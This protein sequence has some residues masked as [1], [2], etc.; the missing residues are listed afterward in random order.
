MENK[1]F[2]EDFE[3]FVNLSNANL[4]DIIV[5]NNLKLELRR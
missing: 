5:I 1:D 3:E 4:R 2:D